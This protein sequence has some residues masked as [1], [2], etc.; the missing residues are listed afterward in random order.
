VFDLLDHTE[1][2]LVGLCDID[3][4]K[5]VNDH[6][7]HD[8]GDLLL[9]VVGARLTA[10]MAGVGIAA[11]LGGDEFA[12]LWT[13]PP[14]DP[15]ADGAAVLDRLSQPAVIAGHSLTPTASLGLALPGPGITGRR[16][17]SAADTAMYQAKRGHIR[18][19]LYHRP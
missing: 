5:Q 12:L 11:R 16:L 1:P 8:V 15:V 17:L 10:A 19:Q 18:T 4:L 3:G 6:H 13:R 7:G 14:V 2:S 9:R